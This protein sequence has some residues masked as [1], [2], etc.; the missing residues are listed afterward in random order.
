MDRKFSPEYI[1][2]SKVPNPIDPNNIKARF[3][4]IIFW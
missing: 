1:N 3:L 4:S 2:T